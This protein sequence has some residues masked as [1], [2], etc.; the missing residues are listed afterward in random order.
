LLLQHGRPASPAI[1]VNARQSEAPGDFPSRIAVC[2]VMKRRKKKKKFA[3]VGERRKKSQG[4]PSSEFRANFIGGKKSSW[5]G[6]HATGRT[7]GRRASGGAWAARKKSGR[8]LEML[9]PVAMRARGGGTALVVTDRKHIVIREAIHS[10]HSFLE[11]PP[12]QGRAQMFLAGKG[13]GRK[14]LSRRRCRLSCSGSKAGRMLVAH[15]APMPTRSPTA[16]PQR[17]H[18]PSPPKAEK[19][20]DGEAKRPAAA[21]WC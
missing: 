9:F 20:G 2:R 14:F 1:Y 8:R 19:R 13:N 17:L 6:V 4:R 11:M 5:R 12:A 3:Q 18:S 7:A 10:G 16:D 21:D 15:A